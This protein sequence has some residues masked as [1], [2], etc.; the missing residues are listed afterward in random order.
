MPFSSPA[1]PPA[2][3]KD[4]RAGGLLQEVGAG[5]PGADLQG[6][7]PS[8]T[9]PSGGGPDPDVPGALIADILL[10]G[11]SPAAPA[12]PAADQ[13][14]AGPPSPWRAPAGLP[15][16]PQ[17]SLHSFSPDYGAAEDDEASR[18]AA[19]ALAEGEA[20]AR[21]ALDAEAVMQDAERRAAAAEELEVAVQV[22][23][24]EGEAGV[25]A[26]GSHPAEAQPGSTGWLGLDPDPGSPVQVERLPVRPGV[27]EGELTP[28]EQFRMGVKEEPREGQ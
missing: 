8:G 1:P 16:S 19:E 6:A 15:A 27:F 21:A 26:A 17:H 7:T 5:G 12:G 14:A 9:G 18:V 13:P 4:P 23:V 11:A 3:D 2:A 10:T 20:E 22:P 24:P 28:P 25:A